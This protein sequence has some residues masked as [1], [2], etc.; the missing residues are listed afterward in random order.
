[1]PRPDPV[2]PD[3]KRSHGNI[4]RPNEISMQGIPTSWVLANEQQPFTRAVLIGGM[5]AH[6]ALPRGV[7]RIHLDRKSTGERGFVA[8]QIAQF[9]K[10]PLRI[11]AIGFAGLW[12][13]WL[14]AFAVFLAS[15]FPAFGALS[16]IC[17][18]F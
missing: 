12:G 13:D 9:G 17:Q 5:A 1:M 14:G 2:V 7:V 10:G 4:P 6:W 15:S 11:H 3:Q 8:D 16:N 18:V